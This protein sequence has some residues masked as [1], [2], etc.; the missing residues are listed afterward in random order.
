MPSLMR[1]SGPIIACTSAGPSGAAPAGA[2]G[3]SADRAQPVG[4]A[5]VHEH[6]PEVLGL[7]A[8]DEQRE[9]GN[10]AV[11]AASEDDPQFADRRLD[12]RADRRRRAARGPSRQS[13]SSS[14]RDARAGQA[15]DAPAGADVGH[16]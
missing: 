4:R 9:A 12:D 7:V 3:A 14:A 6:V 1:R 16:R 13:S 10:A 11:V 5:E 2:A 8:R 15:E